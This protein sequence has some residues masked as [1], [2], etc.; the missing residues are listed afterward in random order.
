M[1]AMRSI[2]LLVVGALTV[3]IPAVSHA[4][5]IADRLVISEVGYDTVAEASASAS[6][7]YIEIYNPTSSPVALTA[8]AGSPSVYLSD[9]PTEYWKLPGGGVAV[10]N[11]GDFVWQFPA[12]A[13]IGPHSFLVVCSDSSAFL[14]EFYAG[15]LTRF[16]S[17]PGSPQLF[18]G[19]QDGAADGVPDMV[20]RSD[21]PTS[22]ILANTGETAIL[23]QWDGESDLVQDLDVVVWQSAAQVTNKTGQSVDGP[24]ADA[25]PSFYGVDLGQT[26]SLAGVPPQN[27]VFGLAR[28]ELHEVGETDV[29]GN[30]ASGHDET[31]ESFGAGSSWGY[32]RHSPGLPPLVGDASIADALSYLA[33]V[34]VSAADGPGTGASPADFGVDGTL[35]ELY[36]ATADLD[37]DRVP[38]SL[39]VAVRGDFF[40]EPDGSSNVSFVLLDLDPASSTG[41]TQLQG[42]GNDLSDTFGPLDNRITNAGFVLAPSIGAVGAGF[43]AAVGVDA[44]VTNV[45][46]S[47]W[48]GFGTAGTAGSANDFAFGPGP[49]RFQ[50]AIDAVYPGAPGTSYAAPEAFE[51]T[52]PLSALSET[53]PTFIRAVAVTTS[54]N[55][56]LP[57]PNTLPESAS[58]D[59]TAPHVITA[60]VCYDVTTGQVVQYFVDADNDNFGSTT[61]SP[62]CGPDIDGVAPSSNDCDDT[63]SG[64]HPGAAEQCNGIDD[65][66][67]GSLPADEADGDADGVRVC[68]GD[69]DDTRNDVNPFVVE[70]CDGASVD[71]DC[72][73][74][75][76]DAD[77]TV[78]GTSTFFADGDGDGFGDPGNPVQACLAASGRVSD[79]SDCNDA[80]AAV[81]PGALE[82][83]NGVDDDCNGSL[84]ASE[85]DAD[86]DTVRVCAGDCNDNAASVHP[87]ALE[88]CNGVDDNCDGN[89]PASEADADD[90]GVRV[91]AGDCNDANAGVSPAA[92]ESCDPGNV[93]ENCN[94]LADDADSAATGKTSFFTDVD[95]DGFGTGTAQ[96]RCDPAGTVRATLAGDCDDGAALVNPGAAEVCDDASN[97]ENCNG[98]A[99]DADGAATGKTAFFTDVDGDGFGTGAAQLRCHA[100]GTVRATVAGD[101]NDGSATIRPG[102]SEQCN[103]LDDNC[104][105]AVPVNEADGDGDG[106]RVCAGDCND[107]NAAV[108]PGAPELCNGTDDNCDGSVPGNEA[109]ADA[110][111]FRACAGDCNDNAASVHPG[112]TELC[113][114]RDDNC[115]GAVP[116]D[117]AD[118]DSDGARLCAG[119]CNDGAAGIH[120]GAVEVCNGIDDNCDGII[121]SGEADDD[122]DGSRVCAGDCNDASA[123]IHPGAAELCNGNDDDCDAM[124][125]ENAVDAPTFFADADGDGF[126]NPA[127]SMKVCTLPAGFVANASDCNDANPA[128]RPGATEVCNGL[129]DD[130]DLATDE[131]TQLPFYRD[132][133][134]DGFGGDT[135]VFGCSAPPGFVATPGDCNDAAAAVHPGA[136]EVCNG[137]DDD[138]A[139]GIPAD[140]VDGDSDGVRVCANDCNDANPDIHPGLQD[141]PGDG[142]DQD[143]SG[144]DATGDDADNDGV[145]DVTDCNDHDPAIHPGAAEVCD[146]QD[147]DCDPATD[148][149]ADTDNDG[150]SLCMLDCAEDNPAI[151][152]DAPEICNDL[153]DNC[154]G[155]IDE[156]FQ[157]DADGDGEDNQACGGSDCDDS[158]AA[159][160]PGATDVP[161]DGID[162]DCSGADAVCMPII[163]ICNN[164]LDDDCDGKI[165]DAD[166]QCVPPPRMD[167]CGCAVGARSGA[168][169]GG[170]GGAG[171]ALGVALLLGFAGV[172]RR[173]RELK[174]QRLAPV[175]Q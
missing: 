63:Q 144:T 98:L 30:G 58:N 168:G 131:G 104:D 139:G 170:A 42:F 3:G 23:F 162:Q 119:D 120:P 50:A 130:C 164:G 175:R 7:E 36:L 127:V 154:D 10:G 108:R 124:V 171:V 102:A 64:R 136:L 73:G 137:A 11:N 2:D 117:E 83:C 66:C 147:T 17:L 132:A 14:G 12:G 121:P 25:L 138:C 22:A 75:V 56:G 65:D 107:A 160:H 165:D 74:L 155:T 151:H 96:L 140:E 84:P 81:H 115:D 85:A 112:A 152:P 94:G 20:N 1:A 31:S 146:D 39:Y 53:L 93:D 135:Q 142:I 134:G 47:G 8:G 87:G 16:R 6:A 78:T 35:T 49:A 79:S 114:G 90:D 161:G 77:P 143:C 111:G 4:D 54:D 52:I 126:G 110:D 145:T 15:S 21:A 173:G 76:N 24:D 153:D 125:D 92:P 55:P 26:L 103:G 18:E 43:D 100:S 166:S 174:R 46:N 48:R 19:T 109:D 95:G 86:G 128:V 88:A 156:G 34:A 91:C 51:A 101:C 113:N 105:G 45:D 172:R 67:N 27:S 28:L 13:V 122:H 33:P 149:N 141:I 60:T 72:D 158:S 71:E 68:A 9:A 116:A 41:A 97:D 169:A 29:A 133:D 59:F 118:A 150:F 61:P 82:V 148:E 32:L 89:V 37:G 123:A 167:G 70:V 44:S 129:D 159:V 163:E 38:E 69:C 62:Y 40:G 99:D 80:S 57:S 5:H 157:H 106:V